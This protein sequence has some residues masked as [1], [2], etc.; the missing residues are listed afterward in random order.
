M[1]DV[2][3]LNASIAAGLVPPSVILKKLEA[4]FGKTDSTTSCPKSVVK[5][6][7]H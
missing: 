5:K 4:A 6:H 1:D 2:L 3:R 7:H